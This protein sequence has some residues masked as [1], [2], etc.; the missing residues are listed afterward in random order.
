M[1]S[2]RIIVFSLVLGIVLTLGSLVHYISQVTPD[3]VEFKHGFPL[4]WLFHQTQSIAG[5]VDFW[6]VQWSSLV[7]DLVFWCIISTMLVYVWNN[8]KT[9]RL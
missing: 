7:I 3:L 4:L 6:S 1:E 8:Y 9:K 5:S 2:K